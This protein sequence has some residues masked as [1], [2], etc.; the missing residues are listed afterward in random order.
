[1]T[2]LTKAQAK[3]RL[4]TGDTP[5]QAEFADILDSIVFTPTAA[6]S[7]DRVVVVEGT[8]SSTVRRI[9][10]VGVALVSART[11]AN[12]LATLGLSTPGVVGN[13]LLSTAATASA[14]ATLDLNR[15]VITGFIQT[16][17]AR[18]Y[19][20]DRRARFPYT[21]DWIAAITSAG[22]CAVSILTES[23]V[24]IATAQVTGAEIAASGT[25]TLGTGETLALRV[26]DVSSPD[27][28]AFT[29]G[30]TRT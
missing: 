25:N 8:V 14:Q 2:L 11:T 13:Q 7:G 18:N 15:D 10:A 4:E 23:S 21:I 3:S 29:I 17:V 30:I 20:L 22:H 1:M 19:I 6:V 26:S 27:A 28:L 24:V 9:G 16:P 5:T 12:A